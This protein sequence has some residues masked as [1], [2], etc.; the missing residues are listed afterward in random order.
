MNSFHCHLPLQLRFYFGLLFLP[1]GVRGVDE[2][3]EP[4]DHSSFVL[5]FFVLLLVVLEQFFRIVQF[6]VLQVF[7]D[8][9]FYFILFAGYCELFVQILFVDVAIFLILFF[10]DLLIMKLL[11]NGS[12]LSFCSWQPVFGLA[13]VSRYLDVGK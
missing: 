5:A 11:V 13:E 1:A 10:H 12:F 2:I 9:F 4:R 8:K 7:D 6:H 3:P